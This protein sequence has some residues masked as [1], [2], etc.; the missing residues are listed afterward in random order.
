MRWL[1]II[2]KF[3]L[4]GRKVVVTRKEGCLEVE[5]LTYVGG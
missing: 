5:D 1:L 3:L 4:R 2:E